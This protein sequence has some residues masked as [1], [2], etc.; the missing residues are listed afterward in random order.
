MSI[1]MQ[2]GHLGG[3]RAPADLAEIYQR[4]EQA[5]PAPV[6]R[7]FLR[8][9]QVAISLP[10]VDQWSNGPIGTL[11]QFF[12]PSLT[13]ASAVWSGDPVPLMRSLERVLVEHSLGLPED[14]RGPCLEAIGTIEKAVQWRLRL[15]QMRMTQSELDEV[16]QKESSK[17]SAQ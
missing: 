13:T 4:P 16:M 11:T 1:P 12:G 6:V 8:P 17:R 5:A 14:K 2:P 9:E 7:D 10:D 3:S 15:Q